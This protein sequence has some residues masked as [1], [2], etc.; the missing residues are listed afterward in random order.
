MQLLYLIIFQSRGRNVVLQ[1]AISCK[2][3]FM[4]F[5][6]QLMFVG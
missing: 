2:I 4:T 5:H 3:I 6:L 1:Y